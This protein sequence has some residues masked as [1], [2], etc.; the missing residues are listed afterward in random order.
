MDKFD[1]IIDFANLVQGL[2]IDWKGDV[3]DSQMKPAS[4]PVKS[5]AT[6]ITNICNTPGIK[7]K[8]KGKFVNIKIIFS[9]SGPG[10]LEAFKSATPTV[11]LHASNHGHATNKVAYY[12][13]PNIGAI[14]DYITGT[15]EQLSSDKWPPSRFS[16]DWIWPGKMTNTYATS[17]EIMEQKIRDFKCEKNPPV[18]AE[19]EKNISPKAGFTKRPVH[20]CE[21]PDDLL[22][23]YYAAKAL[24]DKRDCIVISNDEFRSEYYLIN[25]CI[26]DGKDPS[27]SSIK[28]I[29]AKCNLDDLWIRANNQPRLWVQGRDPNSG[30]W[31][32]FVGN[33][34]GDERFYTNQLNY[35][36]ALEYI[37]S[38][39]QFQANLSQAEGV[40][41]TYTVLKPPSGRPNHPLDLISESS[42]PTGSADDSGATCTRDDQLGPVLFSLKNQEGKD[43]NPETCDEIRLERAGADA[44]APAAGLPAAAADPDPAAAAAAEA[45]KFEAVDVAGEE[46][47]E[48]SLKTATA[49]VLSEEAGMKIASMVK[50]K[51]RT[52]KDTKDIYSKYIRGKEFNSGDENGMVEEVILAYVEDLPADRRWVK[53]SRLETE[54]GTAPEGWRI[55]R[56]TQEDLEA[57]EKGE[58]PNIDTK[59]IK[60]GDLYWFCGARDGTKPNTDHGQAFYPEDK[61]CPEGPVVGG[62]KKT[63]RKKKN[64]KKRTNKRSKTRK[65]KS[66]RN[67]KTKK[68]KPKMPGAFGDNVTL[69]L[70][71]PNKSIR[72]VWLVK[73]RDDDR[74]VIRSPKIGVLVR[75]LKLKRD[76]DFGPEK[77]APK[78]TKIFSKK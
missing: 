28:E 57:S 62:G 45:K 10:S 35:K 53:P 49:T 51:Y 40:A 30:R 33:R 9:Y 74:F 71:F 34:D 77:L 29:I 65:N 21:S 59:H 1:I 47:A 50:D 8:I 27:N 78:G 24:G 5:I 31:Y 61:S 6:E 15:L 37:L 39:N 41:N 73:I 43:I 7:D 2:G 42:A 67:N 46:A 52:M 55:K 12:N 60:E 22:V 44:A 18:V 69:Q 11:A 20:T 48:G 23:I 36:G 64:K 14:N 75:E 66:R 3:M 38:G 17:D 68:F 19:Q 25:G 70:E 76:K 13:D 16:I 72:W 26:E 58:W 56:A 54:K 63:K 4:G 32:E